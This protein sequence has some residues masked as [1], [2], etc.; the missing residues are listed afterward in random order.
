MRCT[1]SGTTLGRLVFVE[2]SN[3]AVR[4]SPLASTGNDFRYP[5]PVAG[6]AGGLSRDS[7]LTASFASMQVET[8]F[9]MKNEHFTLYSDRLIVA[10][11]YFPLGSKTIRLDDIE[12]F[13]VDNG[14]L[15][16]LQRKSWGMA[17]S[18]IWWALGR[19]GLLGGSQS[20]IIIKVKE[21]PISKG[22]SMGANGAD[23]VRFLKDRGIL[24]KPSFN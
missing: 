12:H 8:N 15:G 7:E 14:D 13:V 21:D 17:L 19:R 5:S 2:P 16:A 18:S 1:A 11:Y 4:L 24:Q 6:R 9:V 20:N 3:L 10:W 22:F 23:A